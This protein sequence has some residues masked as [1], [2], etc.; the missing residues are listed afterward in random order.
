MTSRLKLSLQTTAMTA[1]L[2]ALSLGLAQTA[3]A[4]TPAA[5]PAAAPPP[6]E[7]PAADVAPADDAAEASDEE[8][9]VT[10]TRLRV[11]DFQTSN[12]ITSVTGQQIQQSGVVNLTD[13]LQQQP[14]LVNS[15]DSQDS[16]DTGGQ[17][18]AGLN[19]L[20]LRNLGTD[21]TLVLVDGRRHVAGAPGSQSVDINTIPIALI[22]RV[23]ILT[24][25]ASALYGADGVS[26]VVNFVMKRDFEGLAANLLVGAPE[27]SGGSRLSGSVTAGANFDDGKG[28]M[29]WSVEV[30]RQDSVNADQRDFSR[31]GNRLLLVDNPDDAADDPNVF[32][33]IP[34]RNVRY[35]D[36]ST[37]GTVYTDFDFG[38]SHSGAD[39]R[40]DGAVWQD[41]PLVGDFTMVGGDGSLLDEFVDELLPGEDREAVNMTTSYQF[42]DAF[43]VY[44]SAKYVQTRTQFTAQP[45]FDFFL[46]VPIDNAF[47]PDSI[48]NDALAPGGLADPADPDNYGGV[49]VSRDN[50][51]LGYTIRDIERKTYRTVIGADGNITDWLRYDVS[52]VFG[53][54]EEESTYRNNRINERWFAA[55]DAVDDGFGNIVCRSDL[56]PTA[57]PAGFE[58][59]PS[60]FGTTFTPGANSG[61]IPINIFGPNVSAEGA[62]WIN[63]ASTTNNDI[64]QHVVNG[65]IAAESTPWFELQGGP[66]Q[67]A[68]GFEYRKESSNSVPSDIELLAAQEGYDITWSGQGTITRGSFDVWEAYGE[69][70]IPLLADLPFAQELTFDASY[71]VSDYSTTGVSD[72]W[73]VGGKW[74]PDGN[75]MFRGTYA[76]SVRAPNINELFLPQTQTFALLDDPCDDD[77]ITLGTSFRAGNCAA[78]GVPPGFNDPTS[79]SIEGLI[80]GNP[81]LDPE[82]A[83]TWTVG[84]VLTPEFIPGLNIAVDYYSIELREAIQFFSAQT[85]LD[86]CYDL[87]RPNQFCDL[88]SRDPGTFV[89]DGFQQFAV[90]V[91]SYKTD[92]LDFTVRYRLDPADL[93]IEEDIG[94]FNF[95]IAGS[96]LYSLTFQELADA[97]PDET[98]GN[99]GAP[100]Y[101]VAFDM[102]W[103]YHDWQVNY[104]FS[105]FSR[106][107]RLDPQLIEQEP[108]V[109]DPYFF[110]YSERFTHDIQVVYKATDDI[111]VYAGVNNV[112]NQEPDVGSLSQPVGALGRFFYFGMSVNLSPE[113]AGFG[114]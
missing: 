97:E 14:A 28:N 59:D 56:D 107:Q 12:P 30:A 90:N 78:D 22:E 19:L 64:E 8:V 24:G 6:A 21:R 15:F 111:S 38:D 23:E 45:T 17:A 72:A 114:S 67:L 37:F 57:V 20:D 77:N 26:G 10:G 66:V 52:Y 110:K 35:I 76:T 1:V 47:M 94:M 86:K 73:K 34:L 31:R 84:I 85:I 106:T 91:A 27:E 9:V 112:F 98:A 89:V 50:L 51:D 74:R 58:G 109:A 48:R 69:I 39:F 101:Q 18:F 93:G 88:I 83:D 62:D 71:R 70:Q 75:V 25:G 79:S 44:G 29:T 13:F 108:D 63:T 32:D 41:G 103:D 100:K 61:C 99:P 65:F 53:R 11:K 87:P 40:G 46:F 113:A 55:I 33:R 3:A 104:G 92:G 54:T 42:N 36:S 96:R 16:A 7:Q 82:K 60:Q 95:A 102:T 5:E 49:F 43:R 4:Q 105:Y 68:A 81:D 80:G 2:A